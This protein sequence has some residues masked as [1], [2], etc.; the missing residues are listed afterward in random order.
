MLELKA[1]RER[2]SKAASKGAGVVSSPIGA[3]HKL[4]H[5]LHDMSMLDNFHMP[6]LVRACGQQNVANCC[7][8]CPDNGAKKP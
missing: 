3:N 1:D 7:K 4:Q 6:V 5:V 2:D 8:T